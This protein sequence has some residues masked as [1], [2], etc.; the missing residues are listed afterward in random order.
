M[1]KEIKELQNGDIGVIDISNSDTIDK[2]LENY[3]DN[4]FIESVQPNF[5]YKSQSSKTSNTTST[6]DK[7]SSR[8]YYL[9]KLKIYDAWDYL[10]DFKTSKVKVAVIDT[11]LDV[12]HKDIKDNL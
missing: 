6:N 8:Q 9:E 7:Y 2:A 11:G 5:V 1:D 10:K 4:Y 12:N 3:E